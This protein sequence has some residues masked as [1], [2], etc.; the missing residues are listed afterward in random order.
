M[1]N[2]NNTQCEDADVDNKQLRVC[3]QQIASCLS[4][5]LKIL[6]DQKN[7]TPS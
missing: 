5:I 4:K 6:E 3:I 2:N 1:D 7:N